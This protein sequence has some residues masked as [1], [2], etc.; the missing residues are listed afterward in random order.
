MTMSERKLPEEGIDFS[1][2][3]TEDESVMERSKNP[4]V[5]LRGEL[6]KGVIIQYGKIEVLVEEV[7]PRLKFDYAVLNAGDTFTVD[8]LMKDIQF[9]NLLGDIIVS[10]IEDMARRIEEDELNRR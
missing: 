5:A 9:K 6:Y 3:E 7:P 2:L 1:Y 10:T 8:E 4:V